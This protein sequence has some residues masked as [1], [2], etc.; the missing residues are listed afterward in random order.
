MRDGEFTQAG[1]YPLL[2]H[3]DQIFGVEPELAARFQH[4]LDGA[5]VD[6]MLPLV[7][8]DSAPVPSA[9]T[10]G[11]PPGR[12]A[13]VP[14]IVKSA[15]HV[16][17]AITKDSRPFAILDALGKEKGPAGLRQCAAGETESLEGRPDFGFDIV[18]QH[19]PAIGVLAL[20]RQADTA[21]KIGSERSGI[22]IGLCSCYGRVTCHE[23]E[24]NIRTGA[25]KCP[26]EFRRCR[27]GVPGY[28]VFP[29]IE[30]NRIRLNRNG[31][32]IGFGRAY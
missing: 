16:A 23:P 19:L 1:R 5:D 15:D 31:V 24:H 32:D 18:E 22:E 29:P 8:G 9:V 28:G 17:M 11:H 6:C 13:V 25:S 10:F 3:L 20:R 4:G 7:V 30:T 12:Q 26:I 2:T 27:S 21:R 14:G